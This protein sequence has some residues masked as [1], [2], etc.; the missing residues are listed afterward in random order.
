MQPW[1]CTAHQVNT[2]SGLAGGQGNLQPERFTCTSHRAHPL[3]QRVGEDKLPVIRL[4]DLRHTT[5]RSC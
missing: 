5:P 4:H 3:S 2:G 1:A